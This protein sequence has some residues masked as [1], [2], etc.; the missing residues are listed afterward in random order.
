MSR[1]PTSS[2]PS[3]DGIVSSVIELQNAREHRREQ[4]EADGEDPGV[5]RDGDA[6][7]DEA[8]VVGRP[9]VRWARRKILRSDPLEEVVDGRRRTRDLAA[10]VGDQ[11]DA[12]RGDRDPDLGRLGD[13]LDEHLRLVAGEDV[14]PDA[15]GDLAVDRPA[16]R[17]LEPLLVERVLD[18]VGEPAVVD[19]RG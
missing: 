4:G 17:L 15:V 18:G 2:A 13:P 8:D 7:A 3:H 16:D 1:R 10:E 14:L 11:S 19:E 12:L 9:R 6:A 5:D